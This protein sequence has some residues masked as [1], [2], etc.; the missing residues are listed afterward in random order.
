MLIYK[1][2]VTIYIIASLLVASYIIT[3]IIKFIL[4]PFMNASW[5]V[6]G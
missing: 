2:K 3:K 1:A 6:L 4:S 5:E